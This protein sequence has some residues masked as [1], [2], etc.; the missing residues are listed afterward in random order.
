M[1][2][3]DHP[4]RADEPIYNIKA[5]VQKTGIPADTVRAWERRYGMPRP[6]RTDTGRRLYSEQDIA[7]IRWLRERTASGMAISQ[8][9]HQLASLGDAAFTEATP[10]R[11]FG[12]RNHATLAQELLT[13]LLAYDA[14]GAN[15]VVE[16]AFALYRVE[17]VCLHLFSPVLVEIGERWHRQEAS[18]AQE[19]FAAH[20][21]QRRMGALLQTYHP[22][23]G[24]ATIVT[25]CAP[26]ELHELG[27]LMLSVF[28]ARRAWHVVYL[29]AN[30]PV[31]DLVQAVDRLRPDLVCLSASS[32]STARTLLAATEAINL[33]PPPTPLVAYGGPPFNRDEVPPTQARAHYLGADAAV[34][35]ARIERLL[36]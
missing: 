8:A 26:D 2:E 31:A 36:G 18:V 6:R 13:A 19:H 7:T 3:H 23:S 17:E 29:G 9:V 16:E 10:E 22:T 11:D 12:P 27:I 15:A 32:T 5:V 14:G 24:R 33:L 28:L 1:S 21:I 20:F 35:A 34:V 30:V 4:G 25:A